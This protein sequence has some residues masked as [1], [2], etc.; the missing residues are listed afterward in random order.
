MAYY[1]E[2]ANRAA[3]SPQVHDQLSRLEAENARLREALRLIAS[4]ASS[5]A[6]IADGALLHE[7]MRKIR[8]TE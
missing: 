8:A 7:R 1:P 6:T 3:M 4:G 5:P 2:A